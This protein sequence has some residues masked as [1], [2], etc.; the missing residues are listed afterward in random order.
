M[1]KIDSDHY[2]G[3]FWLFE[4]TK[5]I[6]DLT[7]QRKMGPVVYLKYKINL[8]SRFDLIQTILLPI[9]VHAH[10]S[11]YNDIPEHNNKKRNQ[12]QFNWFNR[13]MSH[14][15]NNRHRKN[16]KW[17]TFQNLLG[18]HFVHVI[19]CWRRT[20]EFLIPFTY[21]VHHPSLAYTEYMPSMATSK[22]YP[23]F[24]WVT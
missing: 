9:I 2:E 15:Y 6:N 5:Y 24:Y 8:N 11:I 16:K 13:T 20:N 17:M 23:F 3:P 4:T 21:N 18:S 14:D 1:W 7:L 19:W 10:F 22:S 12:I